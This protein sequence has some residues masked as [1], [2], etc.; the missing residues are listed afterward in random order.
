MMDESTIR[1]KLRQL[2]VRRREVFDALRPSN[3]ADMREAA[4]HDRID[5]EARIAVLMW[6]LGEGL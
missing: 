2:M 3:P 1:I 5:I 4:A 6:V